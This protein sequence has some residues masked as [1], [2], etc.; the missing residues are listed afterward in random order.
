MKRLVTVLLAAIMFVVPLTGC[1]GDGLE[2]DPNRT[3]LYVGI[4]EGGWGREWIDAMVEEF[5][6]LNPEVQVIVEGK[7]D[8]FTGDTLKASIASGQY[9]LY[10]TTI[11]FADFVANE[12]DNNLLLDITDAVTTPLSEYGE[13]RSI[14]DKMDPYMQTYMKASNQN[15]RYYSIPMYCSYYNIVYDVDLFEQESTP[16][17]FAEDGTFT[18]GLTDTGAKAKWAGQDG[19]IGT[20]DD[21]LPV[22][23]ND[24]R[25][26]I[27]EMIKYGIK[28]FI[29]GSDVASYRA[30]YF[31]TVWA[32]YEGKEN[33]DL[34]LTFDGVDTTLPG[35]D[36][37]ESG[38]TG[39]RITAENGYELQK[40]PGKRWALEMAKYIIDNNLYDGESFLADYLSAQNQYLLSKYTSTTG[41][42]QRIAMLIEGGWWENESKAMQEDMVAR[43]GDEY[44]NRRFGIMTV[45]RFDG[46]E[47]TNK[48]LYSV[49]GNSV[50]FIRKN[51]TQPELAK[52]FLRFTT[53][54]ANLRLYT[55]MTGSTRAYDYELTQDDLDSMSYYKQSLWDIFSDENTDMVYSYGPSRLAI[56]NQA[57]FRGSWCWT[58][59]SG[60]RQLNE[61]TTAFAQYGSQ[62]T[63][64]AYMDALYSY[65]SDQWSRLNR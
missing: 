5:E 26:L 29:W 63:V 50:G 23:W 42:R 10:F 44:A 58:G 2:I 45:P 22:T 56:N 14:E 12:S 13:T 41:N 57:Y 48:V 28:P 55:R 24:F 37:D 11:N 18:T 61:P 34:N 35:T 33:F 64:D 6:L 46:Q 60:G 21:G 7:K 53:T 65:H 30:D 32:N 49:T 38:R 9:D 52:E 4:Y 25:R 31:T 15:D 62:L 39:L 59:I 19:E 54:D 17:Y 16:L 43:Y 36:T 40:Q 1:N 51:A 3:Q 47:N 20:Y 27:N 8:E